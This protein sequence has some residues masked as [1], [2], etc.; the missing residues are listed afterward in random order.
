MTKTPER[1]ELGTSK[2]ISIMQKLEIRDGLVRLIDSVIAKTE[3]IA[4]D[5]SVVMGSIKVITVFSYEK[6]FKGCF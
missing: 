2:S 4:K 3:V 5:K 6:I 1:I